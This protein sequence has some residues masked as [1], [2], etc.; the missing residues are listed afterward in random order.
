MSIYL[1]TY[2][3]H[4]PGQN[5]TELY[6]AIKKYDWQ[7]PLDSVWFVAVSQTITSEILYKNL[8][9]LIGKD[10]HLFIT[11]VD[12]ADRQGWMQGEFVHWLMEK[13]KC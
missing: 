4:T 3:L 7:H 5:Y 11:K 12:G 8:K 13:E 2:D 10:D 6:D 9:Q 1:I